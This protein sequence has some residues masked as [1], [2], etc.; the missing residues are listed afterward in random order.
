M[1]ILLIEDEPLIQKSL[2]KLLA[3]RGAAIT[4]VSTGKE[5]MTIIA[6]GGLDRIIC[7]LMLRDVTG[8]DIIEDSKRFF[9]LR[10]IAQKFVI[11]T[12]YSSSQVLS[13][14]KEYQCPIIQKPF[15]N[16]DEALEIMLLSKL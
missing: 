2:S 4:A 13:R 12:A 10:D 5:A 6:Q 14:A 9:N 7:D 1:N 8:F 3:K 15:E 16:L 11:I